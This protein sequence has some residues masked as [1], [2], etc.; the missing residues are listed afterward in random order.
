MND[1][2]RPQWKRNIYYASYS[3]Q[4]RQSK[5]VDENHRIHFDLFNKQPDADSEAA[6]PVAKGESFERLKKIRKKENAKLEDIFAKSTVYQQLQR[7]KDTP[8]NIGQVDREGNVVK[9]Y[10]HYFDY[11]EERHDLVEIKRKRPND[12]QAEPIRN[13][14]LAKLQ[15]NTLNCSN[16]D[17]SAVSNRSF[18]FNRSSFDL[19]IIADSRLSFRTNDKLNRSLVGPE[20]DAESNLNRLYTSL[21]ETQNVSLSSLENLSVQEKILKFCRPQQVTTFDRALADHKQIVKVGEGSFGEVYK[22]D[23]D[24]ILKVIKLEDD[25]GERILPEIIV[26]FTLNELQEKFKFNGYIRVKKCCLV[27]GE[28]SARL[29]RAWTDYDEQVKVSENVNPST[30]DADSMF[31]LLFLQDGGKDLEQFDELEAKTAVSIFQQVLLSLAISESTISFEHRDL[32]LGNVLLRETDEEALTFELDGR[33]Y[34]VRSNAVRTAI[35]DY[36]LARFV[37]FSLTFFDFLL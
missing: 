31:I 37:S 29:L 15:E 30:F 25:D 26:S 24:S 28:Y 22:C 3:R 16:L 27:R 32:H 7:I 14:T 9:R 10:E 8:L 4:A 5:A 36:S 13:K 12:G 1:Y 20:I 6:R 11:E 33:S 17:S 34:T 23:D 35:I 19:S 2:E 21:N 18:R